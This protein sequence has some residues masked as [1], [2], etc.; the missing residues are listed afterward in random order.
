MILLLLIFARCV[1]SENITTTDNGPICPIPLEIDKGI[2]SVKEDCGVDP[3]SANFETSY[4]GWSGNIAAKEELTRE[5]HDSQYL[6]VYDRIAAWQGPILDMT[7]LKDCLSPNMAYMLAVDIR[8][9]KNG[10]ETD[11]FASGGK[12]GCPKIVWNHMTRTE[13][14]KAW[15]LRTVDNDTYT[16][17]NEWFTWRTDFMLQ[18][19]Y[20]EATDIFQALGT[21]TS[22]NFK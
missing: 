2:P 13:K 4:E 3:I 17:D 9:R 16:K 7:F 14:L 22:K 21:M 8:L 1:A 20:I 19:S 6:R 12:A 18:E 11:C 10:T 15:T 5:N